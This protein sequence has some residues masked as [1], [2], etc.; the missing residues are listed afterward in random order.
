MVRFRERLCLAGWAVR[1]PSLP[2]S[3]SASCLQL[4][5]RFLSLLLC[6][7]GHCCTCPCGLAPSGTMCPNKVF[8]KSLPGSLCSIKATEGNSSPA[9]PAPGTAI[10]KHLP[11]PVWCPLIP[12]GEKVKAGYC[13]TNPSE[14]YGKQP[15]KSGLKCALPPCLRNIFSTHSSICEHAHKEYSAHTAMQKQPRAT[16][17]A[18]VGLWL[19]E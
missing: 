18:Q 15:G 1:A 4:K 6:Y 5:T 3:C 11:Y 12:H 17:R 16:K 9:H 8:S 14:L 13:Q 2:Y 19:S 10:V 7:L